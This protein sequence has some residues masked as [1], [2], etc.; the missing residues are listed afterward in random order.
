MGG[1]LTCICAYMLTTALRCSAPK[2]ATKRIFLIT[3]EDDPNPGVGRERLLTSAK[4]TLIV[5]GPTFY[6][7]GGLH[8]RFF[9]GPHASRNNH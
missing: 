9:A 2:T 4:T 5:G 7:N 8:R 3:D 6:I 1:Q